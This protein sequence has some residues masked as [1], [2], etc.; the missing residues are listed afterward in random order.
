MEIYNEEFSH[1][2]PRL[3]KD[4]FWGRP[5]NFKSP[6]CMKTQFWPNILRLR[7]VFEKKTGKKARS[8]FKLVYV[9][10][11]YCIKKFIWQNLFQETSIPSDCYDL[12]FSVSVFSD[13]SAT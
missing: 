10:N 12:A 1:N 4:F 5:I 8:I 3:I 9:V 13:R 7:R 6:G 11:A 2:A